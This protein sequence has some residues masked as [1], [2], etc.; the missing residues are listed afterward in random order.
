MSLQYLLLPSNSKWYYRKW[1]APFKFTTINTALFKFF[2]LVLAAVYMIV[3][4]ISEIF[5]MLISTRNNGKIIIIEFYYEKFLLYHIF[6][7]C[8]ASSQISFYCPWC[9]K[10]SSFI[11]SVTSVRKHKSRCHFFSVTRLILPFFFSLSLVMNI[12]QAFLLF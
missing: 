5:D 7:Y 4:V 3:F 8:T 11:F 2:F 6:P 9:I 1:K 12:W 10:F